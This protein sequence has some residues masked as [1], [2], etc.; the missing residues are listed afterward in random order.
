MVGKRISIIGAGPVGLEA[1]LYAVTLGHEV[2]VYERGNIGQHV[3]EWGHIRLFSQFAINHSPLAARVLNEAG[4]V[5]PDEGEYQTGRAYAEGFLEPLAR[6]AVLRETLRERTDVLAIGRDRLLKHD[7]I[8][9]DRQVY[10][11]RLLVRKSGVESTETAD[12]VLDCSGTWRHANPLGNGGIPAPGE[13]AAAAAIRYRLDDILGADRER[14]EGKRVMLV[15]AGHSAA[16]A[17]DQF[18]KLDDPSVLWVRRS[19]GSQPYT[20]HDED[21]LPER[22]R[23]NRLGNRLAGGGEPGIE[24]RD[25]TVVECLETAPGGTVRVTLSGPS[26]V[27][28]VEVDTLLALVGFRPDRSLYAELQ[29]HECW[30]TMGP[31]KLA[32]TLLAADT[33]DCL[34]QTSA[35]ADTLTSPEPG[36]FILGAKSY[37]K[38]VNFLI[39]L[40]L[41]QIR[42][43]FTLIEDDP[44]LD[45]YAGNVVA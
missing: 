19:A 5:L 44:A 27:E 31:M 17:L 16:T 1:A 20:V 11:F 7:L 29:V 45:L 15:G 43:V 24:L 12:I 39:R 32:A 14:Y 35:G 38:N 4:V 26:G 25:A 42:D 28:T 22:D 2:S 21:P 41:E 34:T 40:G 37:G 8:G 33:S 36:F 13:A 30:A 3:R 9:G 6:S 18:R 23:L 10:P